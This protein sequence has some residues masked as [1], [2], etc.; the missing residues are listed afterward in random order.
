M[1]IAWLGKKS[2]FCGNV[3]YGREIT[4]AL[5]DRG[6]DVSFFHFSQGA[7]DGGSPAHLRAER[8]RHISLPCLYK[9]TLYTIPTL[10]SQQVLADALRQ[11]Q[12]D[13]VHASLALSPLDFVLPDICRELGIPSVATFHPPFARR[14]WNLTSNTQHFAYQFHAPCLAKYDMTIVFSQVQRDLLVQL[15]VPPDRVVVIPNGVD[16]KK[17]SPGASELKLQVRTERVF[18]YQ[19]RISIEKNVESLLKA[20]RLAKMGETCRLLIVGDGPLAEPLRASYGEADG[21]RWLGYVADERRRIEILRGA[22]VFSQPSFVEG[23]SLSLLEAMA[24]GIACIATDVGADGEVLDKG[25]GI[26]LD[27]QKVTAQLQTI[28]PLLR[29]HPEMAG[30]LSYKARQRVLERYTLEGNINRLEGLYA[31]FTDREGVG[32]REAAQTLARPSVDI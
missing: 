25:A 15:G 13:I 23:L 17:Y 7:T 29:D 16:A 14:R 11:L 19:G 32:H 6:Y 12:P 9:S 5:I 2:P 3:T 31:S 1:H 8:A 10:K 30:I 21:V 4:N 27:P 20:W 26:V 28:L 18:L 24:C 22:D